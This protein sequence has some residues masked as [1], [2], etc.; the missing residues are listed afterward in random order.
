MLGGLCI[1]II[2]VI[3]IIVAILILLTKKKREEKNRSGLD[4]LSERDS[5]TGN[6]S[7]SLEM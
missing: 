5:G 2:V 4:L 3:V 7:S 1:V 6:R